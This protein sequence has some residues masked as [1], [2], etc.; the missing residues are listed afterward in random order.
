[1]MNAHRI[2]LILVAVL[3]LFL[4]AVP[5]IGEPQDGIIVEG[6]DEIL[7]LPVSETLPPVDLETRVVAAYA[8]E[9]LRMDLEAMIAPPPVPQ[10]VVAAYANE[11][12]REPLEIAPVEFPVPERI[13]FAFANANLHFAPAYPLEFI[14]DSTPPV[15]T[16][17]AAEISSS[18]TV[19]ITW[20]TDEFAD[21]A[22]PCRE[23]TGQYPADPESDPSFV[24]D[25][26]LVLTGLTP[27]VTYYYYVCS[28]DRSGNKACSPEDCFEISTDRYVYLPLILR[29][30]P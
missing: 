16:E 12:L 22:A 1:M 30:S 3:I 15:I 8:N 4:L 20:T 14:D 2:A 11:I 29:D 7:P 5:V 27:D 23:E 21:S 13:V 25:H 17:V 18:T 24:K 9:L 26:E 10:R 28:T 19:T 6:A